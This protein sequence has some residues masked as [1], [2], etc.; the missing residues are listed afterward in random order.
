MSIFPKSGAL[1]AGQSG[2]K[3]SLAAM[4]IL[5]AGVGLYSVL[6]GESVPVDN[7]FIYDGRF[8]GPMAQTLDPGS[9]DAYHFSRMLPSVVVHAGLTAV[10]R[11]LDTHSVVLGFG[12]LNLCALPAGCVLLGCIA[13]ELKMSTRGFWLAFIAIFVNFIHLKYLWYN[14]V[15]TDGLT[16]AL[17]LAM[18]LCFLRRSVWG[19]MATTLAGAFT[20]PT[21]IF[22]GVFLLIFPRRALEERETSFPRRAAAG[23]SVLVAAWSAFFLAQALRTGWIANI[24]RLQGTIVFGLILGA[25]YVFFAVSVLLAGISLS[26]LRSGVSRRGLAIAL[27]LAIAA[28][29]PA[30]LWANH[31]LYTVSLTSTLNKILI[32]SMLQPLGF[33]VSHPTSFGPTVLLLYLYWRPFSRIVRRCGAGPVLVIAMG[34]LTAMT[35]ES[36]QSLP[37]YLM[38]APLPGLPADELLLPTGFIA[39]PGAVAAGMSRI[40]IHLGLPSAGES[41][42]ALPA[43]HSLT[44][45]QGIWMSNRTYAIKLAVAAAVMIAL[46]L[47]RRFLKPAEGFAGREEESSGPEA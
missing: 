10:G 2:Y 17:S 25:L 15:V 45:N 20:W 42:A 5:L 24:P 40:W 3:A 30:H 31:A 14:P 12:V 35:P 43:M 4:L 46:A 6:R 13:K 9:F 39:L 32:R 8:Y 16:V 44:M 27:G 21:L 22:A 7:T 26:E 23:F 28:L 19:L 37:S 1:R 47:A 36:R 34:I 33:L 41:A 29:L 18:L 11:P 38:A